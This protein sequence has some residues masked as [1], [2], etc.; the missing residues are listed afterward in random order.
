MRPQE[1]RD[2]DDK[3]IAEQIATARKE[4]FGLRFQQA[5][6]E[7]ENTSTLRTARRDLARALT[8][9][10]QRGIDVDGIR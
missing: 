8:I 9:A 1:L 10:R 7:L 3:K 6:G 5:T 2:L 4:I